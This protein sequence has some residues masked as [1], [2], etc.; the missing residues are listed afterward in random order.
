MINLDPDTRLLVAR[1]RQEQLRRSFDPRARGLIA[2]E[3]APEEHR[4]PLLGRRLRRA[5]LAARAS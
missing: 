2:A 5:R 1:E 3:P 4:V